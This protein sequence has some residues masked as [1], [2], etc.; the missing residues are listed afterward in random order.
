ML[1]RLRRCVR[2]LFR[3]E[4]KT[5]PIMEVLPGVLARMNQR[6]LSEVEE[7]IHDYGVTGDA[8]VHYHLYY[9]DSKGG[10]MS[11]ISKGFE[12]YD[13]DGVEFEPLAKEPKRR[14]M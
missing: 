2:A 13:A 4:P 9:V 10:R 1:A 7:K 14:G 3:K 12:P 5:Y 6:V 8:E 11:I